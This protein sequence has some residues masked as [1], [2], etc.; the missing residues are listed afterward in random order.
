MGDLEERFWGTQ[1]LKPLV[2][3]RYIDDIFM[4][5]QHGKESLKEFLKQPK[6]CHPTI[7]STADYSDKSV[8]FLDVK[9]TKQ[10]N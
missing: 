6:N 8:K 3:W 2:W 10:N 9:V 1:D 5:W 4:I 7:K